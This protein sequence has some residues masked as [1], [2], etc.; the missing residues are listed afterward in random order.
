MRVEEIALRQEARQM[1]QEAGLSKEELKALVLKDM[2]EKV[3]QAIEKRIKGID[4]DDMIM[5]RVDVAL[6]R[7]IDEIVKKKVNDFF[8]RK[9]LT[10]RATASFENEQAFKQIGE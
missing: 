3:M 9:P 6:N 1:L 7:A 10:I 5:R 2:D 4:F 8:C